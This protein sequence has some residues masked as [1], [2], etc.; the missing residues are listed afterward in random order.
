MDK[1]IVRF[2]TV[3]DYLE[4]NLDEKLEFFLT[5]IF[6]PITKANLISGL[7]TTINYE[8]HYMFPDF[9]VTLLPKVKLKVLESELAVEK[10]VQY[11]L[12]TNERLIFLANV[13]INH[14]IYDLYYRRSYDPTITYVFFARYGHKENE[15]IKGSRTA[16]QE[17][18]SGKPTPLSIAFQIA[19][20][21]GIV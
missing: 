20:E 17:Y 16:A 10:D 7:Y 15:T 3:R 4:N 11:Y 8:L 1:M 9:P 19:Q 21:E 2:E 5:E 14:K 6:D 12:N 18:L 13:E